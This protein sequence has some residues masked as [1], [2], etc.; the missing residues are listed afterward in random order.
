MMV[1]DAELFGD[2]HGM[3]VAA[4]RYDDVLNFFAFLSMDIEIR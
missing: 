4:A 1:P 3:R 2:T